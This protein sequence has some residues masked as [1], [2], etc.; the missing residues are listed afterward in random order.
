MAKPV[1]QITPENR[2]ER[3]KKVWSTPK[4]L[5]DEAAQA[6]FDEFEAGF[7]PGHMQNRFRKTFG[8]PKAE[9]GN[10]YFTEDASYR[11]WD[12]TLAGLGVP[13]GPVQVTVIY[14]SQDDFEAHLLKGDSRRRLK[15]IV[16]DDWHA[17]C[18]IV[19]GSDTTLYVFTEPKMKGCIVLLEA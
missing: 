17:T 14:A 6:A 5:E 7:V 11:N 3:W 18:A 1:K 8:V 13:E 19:R 9:F 16:V 10:R 12:T 2:F 15:N 4:R